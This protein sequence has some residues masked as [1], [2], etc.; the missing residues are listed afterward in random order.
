V[1]GPHRVG[2][3]ADPQVRVAPASLEDSPQWTGSVR[4]YS[5]VLGHVRTA[6]EEFRERQVEWVMQM[7]DLLDNA[8]A[9]VEP[10]CSREALAAVEAELI[11]SHCKGLERVHHVIGNN[12]IQCFSRRDWTAYEWARRA[13][14]AVGEDIPEVGAYT[15][16]YHF[17]PF[18]DLR[19]RFVVL[20]SFVVSVVPN[21]ENEEEEAK[22]LLRAVGTGSVGCASIP[23]DSSSD[24]YRSS[25]F[26][27]AYNALA[28]DDVRRRFTWGN[29]GF[30]K[31][32]LAWLR[33]V[34]DDVK[35]RGDERVMLFAH[36]PVHP[37][38]VNDPD[39]LA[40]D[41]DECLK[42]VADYQDFVVACVAGHDHIGGYTYDKSTHVH[43]LTV[44]SPLEASAGTG[45]RFL[46]MEFDDEMVWIQ[47]SATV[48]EN[49]ISR[50]FP[51]A[52]GLGAERKR[53]AQ[54]THRYV[55]F[56][57]HWGVTWLAKA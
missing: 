32:Q 52:D 39:G 53:Q 23:P 9:R 56:S 13:R 41:Y 21:A 2:I 29:G 6:A 14:H 25:M 57:N 8:N 48:V 43:H 4:H 51:A 54:L 55:D 46:I 3:I 45:S 38:V 19:W 15:H 22:S 42:V 11:R 33:A 34:L 24:M 31:V 26:G 27:E 12:D 20:D 50:A 16:Y 49:P 28:P 18:Q 17:K 47:G 37:S 36:N 30:G 40:Y 5:A 1:T 7:G 10:P 35:A 44:P